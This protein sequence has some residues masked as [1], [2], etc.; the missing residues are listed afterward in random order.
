MSCTRFNRVTL[1]PVI[2]H[3]VMVSRQ[4]PVSH[5]LEHSVGLVRWLSET[6]GSSLRLLYELTAD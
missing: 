3:C 1:M 4:Y 2:K 5:E 6:I